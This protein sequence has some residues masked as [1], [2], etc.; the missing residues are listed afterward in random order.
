MAPFSFDS[1]DDSLGFVESSGMRCVSKLGLKPSLL[2]VLN[3][4]KKKNNIPAH[5]QRG[6][7]FVTK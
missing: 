4:Q 6:Y 7:G 2:T 3:H 1:A 5:C